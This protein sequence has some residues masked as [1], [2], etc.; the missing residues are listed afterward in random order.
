MADRLADI[1]VGLQRMAEGTRMRIE[2][3]EYAQRDERDELLHYVDQLLAMVD[4]VR[5]S[6]LE[7]RKRLMPPRAALPQDT[8]EKLPRV[9][10]QGPK[11]AVQG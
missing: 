8:A 3:L 10:S 7:D 2:D 1:V 6:L 4:K 5:G 9:V 11:A